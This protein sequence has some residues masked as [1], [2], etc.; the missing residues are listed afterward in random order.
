MIIQCSA[1]LRE[2]K[3]ENTPRIYRTVSLH[4]PGVVRSPCTL[5]LLTLPSGENC[6]M[7]INNFTN[8][9][10]HV[11]ANKIKVMTC[12]IRSSE[13]G[14]LRMELEVMLK[15]KVSER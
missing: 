12:P 2:R 10:G 5:L 8:R 13:M 11:S 14:K 4:R 15:A 3:K 9:T 6:R 1:G 7:M